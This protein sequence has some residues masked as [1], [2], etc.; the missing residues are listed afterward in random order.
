MKTDVEIAKKANVSQSAFSNILS[1]RR[2]PSWKVAKRLAETTCTSP[3]LW[4]EGTPK[5]IRAAVESI[6]ESAFCSE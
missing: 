4:L 1:T 3:E 2:R 5:E 6:K